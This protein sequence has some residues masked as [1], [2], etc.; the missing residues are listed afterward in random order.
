RPGAPRR[1]TLQTYARG[2]QGRHPP[3]LRGQRALTGAPADRVTQRL[4][5]AG[6]P[7]IAAVQ[8]MEGGAWAATPRVEPCLRPRLPVMQPMI[9]WRAEMGQ[10]DDRPPAQA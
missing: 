8:G 9:R 5:H 7:V 1:R 2:P 10:P 3:P 6:Q 4:D